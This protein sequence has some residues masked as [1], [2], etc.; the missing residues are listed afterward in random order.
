MPRFVILGT[1]TD[2]GIAKVQD[3]V[4]RAE[5]AKSLA[6]KAGAEVIDIHWLLGPFDL[7]AT[8][9]A[10]DEATMTAVS[11]SLARLGN[12]RG[13]TLRAFTAAEMDKII[14]KMV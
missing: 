1:F 2:Q 13:Q 6:K 8:V 11:L 4:Q 12:V 3:T 7:I 5:N 14:G 10:P 9:E